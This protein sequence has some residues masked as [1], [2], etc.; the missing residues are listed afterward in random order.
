MNGQQGLFVNI[1]CFLSAR[2]KGE[3]KGPANAPSCSVEVKSI[4]SDIKP[5]CLDLNSDVLI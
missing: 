4:G 2:I 1:V 3:I 5:E